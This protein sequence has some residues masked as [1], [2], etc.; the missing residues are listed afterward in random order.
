MIIWSYDHPQP[1]TPMRL[2]DPADGHV[3]GVVQHAR[4]EHVIVP[5]VHMFLWCFSR[6][7]QGTRYE[8]RGPF[9][10]FLLF[11]S[12]ANTSSLRRQGLKRGL[13]FLLFVQPCFFWLFP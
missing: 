12:G 10:A 7:E 1:K 3:M 9:F 11:R 4:Y 2:S 5:I 6:G 13:F 8:G